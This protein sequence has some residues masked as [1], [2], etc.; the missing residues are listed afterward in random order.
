MT[1]ADILETEWEKK[2]GQIMSKFDDSVQSLEVNF[3]TSSDFKKMHNRISIGDVYYREFY[4]DPSKNI[5]STHCKMSDGA[6]IKTHKHPESD[7]YIYVV[8]GSIINHLGGDNGHIIV[9]PEEHD[10][11]KILMKGR[12]VRSWYKIP[13]NTPHLIQALSPDTHIVVKFVIK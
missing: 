7:E 10:D 13:A 4:T 12:D 3:K 2:Y 5:V 9:P 11:I 8:Q 1:K 6:L